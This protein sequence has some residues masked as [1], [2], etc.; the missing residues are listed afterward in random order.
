MKKKKWGCYWRFYSHEW[1][2]N[3]RWNL[4]GHIFM[5][6]SGVK[7]WKIYFLQQFFNWTLKIFSLWHFKSFFFIFVLTNL[8]YKNVVVWLWFIYFFPFLYYFV[9][10]PFSFEETSCGKLFLKI[11]VIKILFLYEMNKKISIWW[12]F[13]FYFYYL[14]FYTLW[15]SIQYTSSV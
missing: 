1:T 13:N 11:M 8:R 7:K 4:M 2:L 15:S 10:V 3:W 6:M 5:K 12:I 14:Q 9:L